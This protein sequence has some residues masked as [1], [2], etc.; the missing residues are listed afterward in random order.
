[1]REAY[2]VEEQLRFVGMDPTGVV[3]S[4]GRAAALLPPNPPKWRGEVIQTDPT[5]VAADRTP[6]VQLE[7]ADPQT[8]WSLASIASGQ[9][10]HGA[11]PRS[12]QQHKGPAMVVSRHVAARHKSSPSDI[13]PPPNH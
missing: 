6:P 12:Q 10:R 2:D 4:P 9:S 13:R 11:D 1:M 5:P 7:V 3:S 8:G